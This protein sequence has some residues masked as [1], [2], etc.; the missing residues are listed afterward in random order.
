MGQIPVFPPP[1]YIHLNVETIFSVT[2]ILTS[3]WVSLWFLGSQPMRKRAT[4]TWWQLGGY[5]VLSLLG[6]IGIYNEQLVDIFLHIVDVWAWPMV[7][8]PFSLLYY[9]F[10]IGWYIH[11]LIVQLINREA[12]DFW[13]M[14]FHHVITPFEVYFAFECGYSAIGLVIMLLHDSADVWLHL[15]KTFNYMRKETLTTGAFVLF[16][17]FFL[18]TRLILLPI[19]PIAYFRDAARTLCGDALSW[20]CFI[21]FGLHLYWF[22]F[23]L[24]AI[25]RF[26]R[27]G[28]VDGDVRDDEDMEEAEQRSSN[29]KEKKRN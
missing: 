8:H 21:L 27:K 6:Y 12:K 4:Q 13:A 18:I 3:V 23:L 24:L 14:V 2:F 15:A 1:P 5:T 26:C 19:C 25:S 16:A 29:K 28:G 10:E 22:Y 17:V 20:T 11:S 9:E 7:H